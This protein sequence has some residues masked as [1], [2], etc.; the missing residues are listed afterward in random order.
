VSLGKEIEKQP[1]ASSPQEDV[2]IRRLMI[3]KKPKFNII[4]LMEMHGYGGD[5]GGAS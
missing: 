2:T 4:K 1:R 5:D 3:L